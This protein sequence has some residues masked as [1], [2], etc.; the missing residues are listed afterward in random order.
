MTRESVGT[1]ATD[2]TPTGGF[3]LRPRFCWLLVLVGRRHGV[4]RRKSATLLQNTVGYH[5][6]NHFCSAISLQPG[7][8]GQ[9]GY[10]LENSTNQH[11]HK[12]LRVKQGQ[13]RE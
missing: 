1:D 6:N 7:Q 4:L 10:V 8:E 12:K 2:G 13:E 11:L 5:I 9:T 3:W